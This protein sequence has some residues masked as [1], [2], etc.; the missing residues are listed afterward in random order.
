MIRR[1][2]HYVSRPAL[3]LFLAGAAGCVAPPPDNSELRAPDRESFPL[4]LDA[5]ELRCATLDC[6]GSAGRN[7]RLYSGVGLRFDPAD[8]PGNGSTTED[9]Y[10][11]SYR[12]ITTLEPEILDAVLS[13]RGA[14]AERLTLVRKARGGEKHAA[15]AV[16][17]AGDAADRCLVSWF[18]PRIDDEACSAAAELGPPEWPE[19]PP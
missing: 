15:G 9:E 1:C 17:T 2:A 12:S 16:I 7:L 14:R 11:I 19:D 13:D 4:V 18:A 3:A 5:L 8:V 10:E 6:H